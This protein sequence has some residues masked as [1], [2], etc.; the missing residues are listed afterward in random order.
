MGHFL[1]RALPA[2]LLA[3]AAGYLAA[4]IVVGAIV[5]PAVFDSVRWA[6]AT[7]P[8]LPAF[9]NAQ[10]QV[11]GEIFG[12]VLVRFTTVEAALAGGLFALAF[13]EW[14]IVLRAKALVRLL[15]AL[16]LA[17][18]LQYQLQYTAPEILDVRTTW[19]QARSPTE[20]APLQRRFDVLHKRSEWLAHL[21]VYL[22]LALAVSAGVSLIWPPA[23]QPR[24][25]PDARVT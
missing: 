8:N 10:N 11:G 12:T 3:V 25:V 14:L 13:V 1:R 19:R 4:L 6:R 23:Q 7:M 24:K 20:A 16:V 22:L 18:V 9:L 15:L 21:R 5:A 2:M 17:G